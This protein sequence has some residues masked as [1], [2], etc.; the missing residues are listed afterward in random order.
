MKTSAS[1]SLGTTLQLENHFF[2][3]CVDKDRKGHNIEKKFQQFY[4]CIT[5]ALES[6]EYIEANS[7]KKHE[8]DILEQLCTGTRE[9]L[10]MSF[11]FMENYLI[12]CT[13]Q[14]CAL[15]QENQMLHRLLTLNDFPIAETPFAGGK[16]E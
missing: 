10:E 15:P 9:S 1:S 12:K 4:T 2:Y 14:M 13:Q 11:R 16:I 7:E 6:V 5:L 8:T 3:R